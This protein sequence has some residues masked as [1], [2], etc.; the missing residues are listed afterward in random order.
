ML[1]GPHVFRFQ[2]SLILR[3]KHPVEQ[4]ENRVPVVGIETLDP[5]NLAAMDKAFNDSGGYP[6]RIRHIRRQGIGIIA[7]IIVGMDADDPAVFGRTLRFLQRTGSD[8]LQLNILTPLPGTPLYDEFDQSG[9][10][11]DRDWEKYDYRHVVIQPARMTPQELQEGADWLYAQYYRLDRILLRTLRTAL[12]CGLLP[13]WLGL[14]LNLT[15]RYD[16]RR[17]GIRGANPARRPGWPLADR[18]SPTTGQNRPPV[19]IASSRG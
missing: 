6:E 9:R 11:I 3:G 7:G 15:Y 14:R 12:T 18:P 16:N 2:K 1:Q 10:I 13:A 4:V 8:S 19:A 17:E 5:D